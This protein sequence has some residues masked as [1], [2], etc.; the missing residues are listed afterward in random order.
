MRFILLFCGILQVVLASAQSA[1]IPL[2][3]PAYSILDRLDIKGIAPHHLHL[4][5]KYVPGIN[6]ANF[7]LRCDSQYLHLRPQDLKDV[8]YLL[9]EY[10]EYALNW[11]SVDSTIRGKQFPRRLRKPFLGGLYRTPEHFVSVDKPGFSFRLNPVLQIALGKN[12]NEPGLLYLNQRGL[13]TRFEIDKKIYGYM[14][15]AETQTYYPDYIRRWAY[16][17]IAVPGQGLFKT[18][19]SSVLDIN[20][21]YDF[22]NTTAY[23]GFRATRHV[24]VQ[25][26][27]ARHFIGNGYRSLFLSDFSTNRFFL[28]TNINVWK[29]RYQSM[30]TE[31]SGGLFYTAFNK[32]FTKRFASIHYLN[33]DIS[34]RFSVGIFESVAYNRSQQIE[35]QYLNPV[36][37]YRSVEGSLGSPDNVLIGL[38]FKYN[39]LKT[40]QLYGQLLVDEFKFDGYF[41]ADERGWWGNK[42]G[43]QVGAKYIDVAGISHLD[44]QVEWNSVRP[45]TYSHNDSLNSWTHFRQ[46]LAHPLGSNFKEL[47]GI[48]R[49][50]PLER[51]QLEARYLYM[52]YGEN[53]E[54]QNWGAQP[55]L[56]NEWRRQEYGNFIGQGIL[57]KTHIAGL[58]ISWQLHHHLYLDFKLLMR[59]QNSANDQRDLNTVSYNFGI[60]MNAWDRRT[61]F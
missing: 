7:A 23:F 58:D 46:P 16:E 11:N 35:W 45:Y 25:L 59:H 33:F 56:S 47:L 39:F 49:Y 12:Q 44:L 32:P 40:I 60:R 20:E 50:K 55:N 61:D 57:S 17:N 10:N 52:Y 36:I 43:V 13:E 42:T 30:L 18:Y 6:T 8:Q 2:H 28:S 29:I 27:H 31:L 3:A 19:K 1:G 14:Q 41:K 5:T 38:D 21:G 15:F 26:G 48:V 9:R 22:N 53:A 37:L 34:R 51:L 24:D 54:R 4:E